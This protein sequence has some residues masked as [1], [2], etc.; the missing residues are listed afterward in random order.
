MGWVGIVGALAGVIAVWFAWRQGAQQQ[1]QMAMI[2]PR[3]VE[4][5]TRGMPTLAQ[6]GWLPTGEELGAINRAIADLDG[7]IAAAPNELSAHNA[8]GICLARL[9][10][11][12]AALAAY[13]R[14]KELCGG[15]PACRGMVLNNIGDVYE[16]QCR[17]KEA[18]EQYRRSLATWRSVV[19][20]ANLAECLFQQN[21][22]GEALHEIIDVVD[23]DP[24][25]VGTHLVYGKILWRRNERQQ[26]L[27]QFRRAVQIDPKYQPETHL[28][29]SKAL[30][31]LDSPQAALDEAAEAVNVAPNF[32]EAHAWY[33]E[34]LEKNGAVSDAD[35]EHR[36]AKALMTARKSKAC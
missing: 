4:V 19:A 23:A 17:L 33:A 26:A 16:E 24:N 34:V 7:I 20:R 27:E 10:N 21:R 5:I 6:T 8:R 9:G 28:E 30:M 3:A 1:A 32:A 11:Y 15:R 29:L 22:V 18:E 36:K 2:V 25:F 35:A 13:G 14:A 12:D 31:V